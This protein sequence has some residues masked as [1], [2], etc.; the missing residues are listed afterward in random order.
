MDQ[1]N[2]E[3]TESTENTEKVSA[4]K[5]KALKRSI[6]CAIAFIVIRCWGRFW[7]WA[8]MQCF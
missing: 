3:N 6:V 1:Y 8:D 5:R 7:S 4:V 2:I